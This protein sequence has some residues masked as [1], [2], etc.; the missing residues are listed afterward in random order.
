MFH[1]KGLHD[2]STAVLDQ[3][4]EIIRPLLTKACPHI[5]L[6]CGSFLSEDISATW[7]LGPSRALFH[8]NHISDWTDADVVFVNSTCFP[9][10]LMRQIETM[11]RDL[12]PGSRVITLTT[13]LGSEYFKVR[14]I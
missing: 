1:Y 4:E 10:T 12:R 3:F 14:D 5:S 8:V 6:R 13:G 9:A 11:C 7:P 2:T